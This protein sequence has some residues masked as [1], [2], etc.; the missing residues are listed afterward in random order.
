MMK[1]AEMDPAT[2]LTFA[3]ALIRSTK[4]SWWWPSI[5]LFSLMVA[6]LSINFPLAETADLQQL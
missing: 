5:L 3:F 2:T 1:W 6:P 4:D